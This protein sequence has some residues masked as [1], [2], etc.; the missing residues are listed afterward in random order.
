MKY[1]GVTLDNTFKYKQHLNH[2]INRLSSHTGKIHHYKLFQKS[3]LKLY[4]AYTQRVLQDGLLLL[5]GPANKTDLKSVD[6]R[7]NRI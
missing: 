4:K 3:L 5:F 6:I 2:S 1:I 7:R